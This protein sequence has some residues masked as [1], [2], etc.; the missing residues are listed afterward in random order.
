[1]AVGLVAQVRQQLLELEALAVEEMLVCPVEE[2]DLLL[3]QIQ[4]AVAV[5]QLP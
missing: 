3:P 2:T 5:V 1:V 4:A